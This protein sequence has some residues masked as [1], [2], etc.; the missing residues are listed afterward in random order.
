M[1]ESTP[2]E[3]ILKRVRKALLNKS[4]KHS[5]ANIDFDSPVFPEPVDS[6]EI[7]FAQ[8]F[9]ESGGKFFFC[10]NA[11]ELMDNIDY[12]LKE[13]QWLPVYSP[14]ESIHEL[15]NAAGTQHLAQ[16]D[17]ARAIVMYC[18]ALVSRTGTVIVSN[19]S[20]LP[21]NLLVSDLPLIILAFTDQLVFDNR[22]ALNSIKEKNQAKLP[23]FLHF[24]SNPGA[25]DSD[26]SPL[27]GIQPRDVYVFVI[28]SDNND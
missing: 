14:S 1:E 21:T 10:A 19:S 20:G 18:E 11:L 6:V 13:N 23:G 2:R 8:N 5:L 26:G 27:P 28:D 15:L 7:I 12:L 17:K 22:E 3:K 25:L 24:I 9:T 16:Y 4:A